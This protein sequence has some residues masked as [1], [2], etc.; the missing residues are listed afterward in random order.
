MLSRNIDIYLNKDLLETVAVFS[1][2]FPKLF[3][4]FSK[5]S[6]IHIDLTENEL[7]EELSDYESAIALFQ[8]GN[9]VRIIP[10]SSFKSTNNY[11]ELLS[12]KTRS[13]FFLDLNEQE[14]ERL[15]KEYGVIIKSQSIQRDIDPFSPIGLYRRNL[16]KGIS[17]KTDGWKALFESFEF[18]PRNSIIISD[19]HLLDNDSGVVGYNN[20][21]SCLKALMPP[22]YSGVFQ[23]LIYSKFPDGEGTLIDRM[24]GRLKTELNNTF[25][26]DVAIEWFL[27]DSK[28]YYLHK[29]R[30]YLGYQTIECDKGFAVFEE[31]KNKSGNVT[32]YRIK[33]DNELAINPAFCLFAD[34]SGDSQFSIDSEDL[35]KILK[36]CERIGNR[37]RGKMES[38]SSDRVKIVGDCDKKN[39]L[40]RNRMLYPLK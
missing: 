6:V 19:R 7:D 11:A 9:D 17:F 39:N 27:V 37:Y 30:I 24:A 13:V 23:V 25:S 5:Y 15:S 20:I 14:A 28:E 31:V 34:Y 1:E 38:H 33:D 2:E 4:F 21:L 35:N 40:P 22:Q 16:N 29:R 8:R 18:L 10:E 26:Y 3:R 32:G 36:N 12:E